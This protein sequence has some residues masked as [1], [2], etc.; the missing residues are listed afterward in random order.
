M[1]FSQVLPEFKNPLNKNTAIFIPSYFD[2]I[3]IR[4][5]FKKEELNFLQINEY[6]ERSNISRARTKFLE[7]R[8]HFLLF[9]ERFY[10]FYRYRIRGIKNIIF[11]QL[12]LYPVFYPE[13]INFMEANTDAGLATNS[14]CSIIYSKYDRNRL[15]NIIGTQQCKQVFTSTK[16]IHMIVTGS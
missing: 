10:F 6:S 4:N 7:N 8:S 15:E 13:I 1:F 11:Y 9:T 3:R 12:P 2:F 5:F 16:N 14:L